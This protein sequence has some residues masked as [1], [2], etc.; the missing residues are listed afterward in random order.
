MPALIYT[1]QLLNGIL[2]LVMLFQNISRGLTSWKRV[3]EVLESV[4][5]LKDGSFDGAA[6]TQ[7]E[8]NSVTFP[9]P[10]REAPE[11]CCPISI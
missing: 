1:T 4:P 9:S 6:Q 5:E 11:T 3:K 2:M 10:I 7:G 8:S